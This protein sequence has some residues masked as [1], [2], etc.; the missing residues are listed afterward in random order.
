VN[1]FF[2]FVLC[3]CLLAPGV[4]SAAETRVALI[5]ANG[6]YAGGAP[7][8]P[9]PVA[10]GKLMASTLKSVGFASVTL[11]TN[12]NR[13]T[14]ERALRTFAGEAEK[15]DVAVVYYA[16]HGIESNGENYLIP[17]DAALANDR[18]LDIEAVKLST[19]T[20]MVEGARRMRIIILDACRT[21]PAGMRRTSATRSI[22]RGLAAVEPA[23]DSLVVYSAKAGTVAADGKGANSPFAA[24]L[25]RRL[26]EPGREINLLFR[27]VRDDVLA[28][29][30][31]VQEP[32]TYGSLSSEQFYFVPPRAAVQGHDLESET[33]ALCRDA[34]TPAPC[35]AYLKRFASGRYAELARTRLADVKAPVAAMQ[36][37]AT[38]QPA[39]ARQSVMFSG[40]GMELRLATDANRLEVI[41]V[42]RNGLAYGELLPGD[43]I[44][45]VNG[46][47]PDS[48]Q[49]LNGQT[50]PGAPVRLSVRRGPAVLS[51]V[52]RPN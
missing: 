10:D 42:S 51:I 12:A 46:R 11:L 47:A 36:P 31:R 48:P 24:A 17:V 43:V 2:R 27:Q 13:M 22:G 35:E 8:L 16:G 4:Q 6:A 9:N 5:I 44:T 37:M 49:A 33:W 1:L 15:A 28:S 30:G 18:D 34:R 7:A 21:P 38:A 52:L 20:S 14:M 41:S 32:F 29:T 3:V 39:I 25:S 40:L 26:V 45:A 50:T 19:M 23:G